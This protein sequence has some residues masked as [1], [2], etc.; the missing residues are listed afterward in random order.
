MIEIAGWALK[1]TKLDGFYL[2]KERAGKLVEL[3]MPSLV[4]R[5][6]HRV[7]LPQYADWRH[8]RAVPM[9]WSKNAGR[10]CGA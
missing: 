4:I 7:S 9:R 8:D 6:L 5:P 2:A 1:W 10:F 3:F